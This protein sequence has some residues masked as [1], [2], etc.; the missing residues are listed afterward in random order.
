MENNTEPADKP[1]ADDQPVAQWRKIVFIIAVILNSIVSLAGTL[2]FWLAAAMF[3]STYAHATPFIGIA[4]TVFC[5][6][7][8]YGIF[9]KHWKKL[10]IILPLIII[11]VGT[12]LIFYDDYYRHRYIPSITL[13]NE[14]NPWNYEPFTDSPHLSRL[15]QP[16]TLHLS[17]ELPVLDGA[18]ALLPVYCSLAEAV[19]P[20]RTPTWR[21]P[22]KH[23]AEKTSM[24]PVV[25]YTNTKG[26]Y[27]ALIKGERDIIFVA[28]PSKQQRE[29]AEKAGVEFNMTPIG[30]EA[31]VFLVN[32]KN[33]VNGLTLQQIKEIYTG[34]ITNWKEVGGSNEPIRPFQRD[35][36][37]GSQTAFLHFMGKDADLIPPE[38]TERAD[39][40][41]GLVKQVADYQNHRNAIGYSFRYYVQTMLSNTD[42][43]LLRI[44]GI[45]PTRENIADHTY[46]LADTFFAVT[47]KGRESENTKKLI[48]WILSDQGQ[49][50]IEKTGYIPMDSKIQK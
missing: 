20:K 42:V 30:Y 38:I 16:A 21:T 48:Q 24:T 8:A 44:N 9:L 4:W 41:G 11:A 13:K 22:P 33:P 27:D 5:G 29:A 1:E 25:D 17:G 40:M 28:M 10:G 35:E 43:K 6:F 19:Y 47:L 36:G 2:M 46:P 39:A 49:R 32:A 37:S 50:I 26:A 18:T 3:H 23:V 12:S 45:A 34:K 31:F 14:L 7:L 15:E